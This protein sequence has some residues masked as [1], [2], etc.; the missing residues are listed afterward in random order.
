MSEDRS[1][2]LASVAI[3]E[4]LPEDL[5]LD[6]DSSQKGPCGLPEG[7]NILSDVANVL[8]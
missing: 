2:A 3:S 5:G 7:S 4:S 1:E 6:R 8:G